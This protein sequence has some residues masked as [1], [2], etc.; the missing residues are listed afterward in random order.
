MAVE[1]LRELHWIW[2]FRL[3]LSWF[4]RLARQQYGNTASLSP[5]AQ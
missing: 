1:L 3:Q 4:W 2:R 5:V